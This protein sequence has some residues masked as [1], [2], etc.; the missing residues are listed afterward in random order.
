MC[1]CVCVDEHVLCPCEHLVIIHTRART[2][3]CMYIPVPTCAITIL[4]SHIQMYNRISFI[5]TPLLII[6]NVSRQP[7][8]TE[9]NLALRIL[10][11]CCHPV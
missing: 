2:Q 3:H 7:P 1:V 9:L 5:I 8:V 4:Y 10:R 6:V 11:L